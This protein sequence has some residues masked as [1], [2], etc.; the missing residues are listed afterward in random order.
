MKSLEMPGIDPGT[1]RMLSERSTIW[2]TPPWRIIPY[3]QIDSVPSF[4]WTGPWCCI[5]GSWFETVKMWKFLISE[6]HGNLTHTQC[7]TFD[8]HFLTRSWIYTKIFPQLN[9]LSKNLRID[10]LSNFQP[11]CTIFPNQTYH[12][13]SMSHTLC[14]INYV[15]YYVMWLYDILVMLHKKSPY[16][17]SFYRIK[18]LLNV[19]FKFIDEVLYKA[20]KSNSQM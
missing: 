20:F 4:S 12:I 14:H 18:F 9:E 7:K 17:M 1:S 15:T 19:N 3:S 16:L 2:A 6:I 11:F 13:Y 5:R 8:H 10:F